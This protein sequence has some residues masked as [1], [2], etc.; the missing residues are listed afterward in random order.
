MDRTMKVTVCE[1][2]I[3]PHGLELDW[4]ALVEHV[5]SE[6]S[7][8]VLLPEMPFYPWVA[9]TNN[10]DPQI[11]QQAVIAHDHW[12]SRLSEL[13]PAIVAGSRPVTLKG[14][15]HN[16]GFTWESGY[17][18]NSSH[19]KYYLPIIEFERSQYR[20]YRIW[21]RRVDY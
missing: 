11:W 5:K 16:Q 21:W 7:D 14:K 20:E 13:S 2:R 17:G 10:V 18:Y 1:L 12:I 3:D 9:G 4:K 15:R 19:I 8:L 6:K